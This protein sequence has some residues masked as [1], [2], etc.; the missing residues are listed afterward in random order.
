M[1]E[2]TA[3]LEEACRTLATSQFV[4]VDTEFLRETTFWPELCLIQIASP[5]LEVLIDPRAPGIS[6]KPFFELMADT[7]V[8]KVFHAARQDIEIIFH[9]RSFQRL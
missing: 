7:N 5:D 8:V 1:I 6:L 4:T 3:Q 9:N 2:T